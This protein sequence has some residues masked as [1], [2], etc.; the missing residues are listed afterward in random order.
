MGGIEASTLAQLPLIHRK[1]I[2]KQ[3]LSIFSFLSSEK[4]MKGWRRWPGATSLPAVGSVV[5]LC[6]RLQECD[7]KKRKLCKD[8][9]ERDK[10][11]IKMKETQGKKRREV[12]GAG[13]GRNECRRFT[14]H[15]SARARRTMLENTPSILSVCLPQIMRKCET[16][17]CGRWSCSYSDSVNKSVLKIGRA[18]FK[19]PQLSLWKRKLLRQIGGF[20]AS[21]LTALCPSPMWGAVISEV[22]VGWSESGYAWRLC[23]LLTLRHHKSSSFHIKELCFQS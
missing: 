21:G 15:F 1:A 2:S 3:T 4:G 11:Q 16:W 23:D 13:E 14:S 17:C 20:E 5:R 12:A 9:Q 19:N 8:K 6:R 10:S 7:I 22:F 18:F